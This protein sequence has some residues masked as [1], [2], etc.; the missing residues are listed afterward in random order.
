MCTISMDTVAALQ[1]A[2]AKA[3][4][5]SLT[6]AVVVEFY[7]DGY[8]IAVAGEAASDVA[9]T[10]STLLVAQIDLSRDSNLSASLVL[11]ALPSAL[12]QKALDK[13]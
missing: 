6:G 8:R 5:G 2:L 12:T 11:Q 4:S 7:A 3:R 1:K 9:R 10:V 13:A